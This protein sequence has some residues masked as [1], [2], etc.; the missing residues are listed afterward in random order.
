MSPKTR[1]KILFVLPTLE[2]GGAERVMSF[3][4]SKLDK[5]K[6]QCTLAVIGSERESVYDVKDI[7]IIYLNK[8]QVRHGFLPLFKLIR[9]NHYDL[10][11]SSLGHV[12]T[13]MAI[14]AII[15]RKVKFIGRETIVRGSNF[16]S[17][18]GGS[19]LLWILQ[20]RFLD[21][22]ICQ[23]NDMYIDMIENFGFNRKKLVVINNP[24]TQKFTLKNPGPK[25]EPQFITVGRLSEHKGHERVLRGLKELDFSFHYK[26]IGSGGYQDS[27]MRLVRDFGL[28]DK[29]SHIPFTK[30]IDR[31][32]SE[33]DCFLSG[34]YV[35]GFSN[36]LIE[37]CA[38]GTPV[39]AFDAPGGINEIVIENVNGYIV[40]TPEEFIN[41]LHDVVDKDWDI[42]S[43][44]ESVISRYSEEIILAKYEDLILKVLRKTER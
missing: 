9:N 12:N 34:S 29:V 17:K 32:L 40:R 19:G 11:L 28:E 27:I 41:R 1:P 38:V 24:T 31:H 10:V 15:L 7:E 14:F 2:A 16:N 6:F 23:S 20:K 26:I 36:A 30:E 3:I 5:Q 33:S 42:N 35:E 8:K 43:I 21:V 37:S 22:M 18:G 13:M 25:K 44:R 4:A 39:I